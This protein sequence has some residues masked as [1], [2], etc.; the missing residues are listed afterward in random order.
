MFVT[1]MGSLGIPAI[2]HHLY[3]LGNVPVF[4]C[5]G[6]KRTEYEMAATELFQ[7]ANMWIIR[8]SVDE[9]ICD[10][11]Y[12][13]SAMKILKMNLRHPEKLDVPPEEVETEI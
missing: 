3:N 6:P 12:F 9:R 13:A 7:N 11:F 5:I 1:S 10:G 2:H 8:F 4:C